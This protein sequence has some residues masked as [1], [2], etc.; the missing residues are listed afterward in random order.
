MLGNFS[1]SVSFLI[2]V[3]ILLSVLKNGLGNEWG[4]GTEISGVTGDSEQQ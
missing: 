4:K 2:K 1:K 3:K